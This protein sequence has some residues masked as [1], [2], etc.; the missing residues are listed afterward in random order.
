MSSGV[1]LDSPGCQEIGALVRVDSVCIF[2]VALLTC[3]LV[4][5]DHDF[6]AWLDFNIA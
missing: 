1:I 3:V 2:M 5:V 4:F 6:D